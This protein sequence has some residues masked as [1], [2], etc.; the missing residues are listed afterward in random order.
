MYR[1]LVALAPRL[2]AGCGL[3][4]LCDGL[5]AQ[6]TDMVRRLVDRLGEA[7]F[8]TVRRAEPDGL[9]PEAVLRR[10]GEQI[11][12]L[13]HD[14]DFPLARFRRWRDARLLVVGRGPAAVTAV[15]SL[16]RNGA[17][18]VAVG[19]RGDAGTAE[20]AWD[21]DL[22][23]LRE[24][25]TPAR[26]ATFHADSVESVSRALKERPADAV[27]L[28]PEETDP[29]FRERL[30]SGT[31]EA[32]SAF[33]TAGISGDLL[34]KGPL[35][36]AHG[37]ACWECAEMRLARNA[38]REEIPGKSG[39]ME[40]DQLYPAVLAAAGSELA[41][42]VFRHLAATGPS[43]L[44]RAVVVQDPLTLAARREPLPADPR[45]RVCARP[46]T[47]AAAQTA[48]LAL[49]EGRL[50]PPGEA[51]ERYERYA[52]LPA[53]TTGQ[54]I[55]FEDGS[56]PQTAVKVGVVRTAGPA[57]DLI[58][59]FDADSLAEARCAAVERAA[60]RAAAADP[61]PPATVTA[62][63]KELGDRPAEVV[64]ADRLAAPHNGTAG[65]DAEPVRW[66]PALS[67]LDRRPVW[68]PAAPVAGA[69]VTDA[70]S[71]LAGYGA[72]ASFAELAL[73][74]VLSALLHERVREWRE[75]TAVAED[76]PVPEAAAESGLTVV[77]GLA[78]SGALTLAELPGAGSARVVAAR[79]TAS[80]GALQVIA[81]GATRAA[82]LRTA[83]V[84]LA[85]RR[86][87]GA[88]GAGNDGGRS[89]LCP[90]DW[91][92]LQPVAAARRPETTPGPDPLARLLA[93]LRTAGRDALLVATPPAALGGT[94]APVRVGRVLLTR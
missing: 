57:P 77:P 93:G 3:D 94:E 17:R 87:F 37:T 50:D 55:R 6:R 46:L 7:G 35:V 45:C 70:P 79:H 62:T 10:F 4:E 61:A 76:L 21:G 58:A 68:V 36:P 83:L 54:L 49:A 39:R 78:R 81:A 42:E 2:S 88:G 12:F 25:G 75:G 38:S 29:E 72:G 28:T 43:G 73:D 27:I 16:L 13:T 47:V 92:P 22:A 66:T 23:E 69:P 15:R 84:E 56:V 8:V 82:A 30:F 26:L 71:A 60:R 11:A 63:A 90:A 53:E 52:G 19:L 18:E 5:D 64:T 40:R 1:W 34:V 9:L 59:G 48:L 74:G 14:G 20:R 31:Y 67:L 65:G 33:V 41:L 51:A 32:G 86:Q 24:A 91:P 80:D 89:L 85:G 44:E